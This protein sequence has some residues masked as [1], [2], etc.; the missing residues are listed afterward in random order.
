MYRAETV[1]QKL[2]FLGTIPTNEYQTVLAD[3]SQVGAIDKDV[4]LL[5]H[6]GLLQQLE[7]GGF[8]GAC[9]NR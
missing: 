6:H 5:W 1:I 4:S 2:N 3:L 9:L 7:Q 8:A